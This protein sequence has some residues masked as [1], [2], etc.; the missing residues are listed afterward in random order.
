MQCCWC[1]HLFANQRR[2]CMSVPYIFVHRRVGANMRQISTEN[3]I[4]TWG[5]YVLTFRSIFCSKRLENLK[6]CDRLMQLNVQTDFVIFLGRKLNLMLICAIFPHTCVTHW[7][8][9]MRCTT[10]THR[11]KNA[12]QQHAYHPLHWPSR[13]VGS[14]CLG[15]MSG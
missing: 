2:Q 5:I 6:Y 11:N 15:G 14:V 12:F 3:I 8:V 7:Q 10:I 9:H 4:F 1:P 13:G